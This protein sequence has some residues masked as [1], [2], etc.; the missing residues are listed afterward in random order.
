MALSVNQ[1]CFTA[2]ANCS[3]LVTFLVMLANQLNSYHSRSR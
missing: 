2:T 3:S 1:N